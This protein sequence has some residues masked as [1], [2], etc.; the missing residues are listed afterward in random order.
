[1]VNKF[2]LLEL[3]ECEPKIIDN[4]AGMYEYRKDDSHG[5]S[6]RLCIFLYDE[7]CSITLTHRD[8][9]TPLFELGFEKIENI[10]CKENRLIIEQTGNPKNIVVHFKPNYT[11]AFE[12]RP[13]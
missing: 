12:D 13:Y 6:L 5:F 10:K 9:K 4:E 8:L 11:L 2:D 3:F 7:F 1:M